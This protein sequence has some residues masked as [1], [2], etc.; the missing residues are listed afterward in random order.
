[1][2][3]LDHFHPP[4][5]TSR[6]W[7]SFYSLWCAALLD[8]INELLPPRYFGAVQVHLGTQVVA[9][10]AEF[11][12][13][14]EG[15]APA[16]DA[17]AVKT[18]APPAATHTEIAVFPDDIE[19]RVFDTRDGAV[20]VGV[21]ALVGPNNND[22][23][24]VRDAFAAKCVTYLQRGIGLLV[25]DIVTARHA[26]LHNALASLM[27]WPASVAFPAGTLLYA[28]SYQPVRRGGRN[29][30]DTWLAPLIVGQPLPVVPLPVRG[31]GCLRLDLEV[32]TRTRG[33]V[34]GFNSP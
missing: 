15:D 14:S 4:F 23:V 31:V 12:P 33:G 27:H 2:P 11:D 32:G 16:N 6:P 18:W 10:V 19:V 7:E 24:E 13:S 28:A 29:R 1:M 30:I 17:V 21:I 3:L 9:D 26:N 25:I 8:Q 34:V 20:L 5:L 22:H